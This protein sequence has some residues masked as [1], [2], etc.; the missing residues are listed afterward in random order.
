MKKT[1]IGAGAER[2]VPSDTIIGIFDLDKTTVKKD[3]RIFLKMA[4]QNGEVE[5][6]G[7]DLP[8]SFLVMAPPKNKC[9]KTAEK[10]KILLSPVSLQTLS[11]RA[12]K[13]R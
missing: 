11:A 8:L 10:Q 5:T 13:I 4:E 12:F 3:S 6:I 9:G 7:Y 1:Y 2:I